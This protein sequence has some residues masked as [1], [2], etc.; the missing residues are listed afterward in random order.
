VTEGLSGSIAASGQDTFTV[1]LN[2]TSAGTFQGDVSFG[3]N[4]ADENPFN[5]RI[6]GEV[7]TAPEPEIETRGNS[8]V[9]AD[10]DTTPSLADH[11]DFGTTTVGAPV[12]HTFTVRNEGTAALT[13]SG[14]TV[15][16]GF[17]VTEG[18]SG[19]IAASGQDTFTVRLNATSAGT[20]QGDVSFGNNDSDENPF[21][22]RIRGEVTGGGGTAV[23]SISGATVTIAVSP[24]PGTSAW[25]L[26]ELIP[27]GLTPS[28]IT[29]PN[30]S[31][32]SSTRKITWYGTGDS[33][34]T[35]GYTVSGDEGTYTVAGTV[36]FDG[37]ANQTVTG[38]ATITI[39]A[40]HPADLNRNWSM[41]MSEAIGYAAGW[42]QGANPMAYA[43]RAL[44]LW[45]NGEA[46]HREAGAEPMCWVADNPSAMGAAAYVQTTA[47][48]AV[49]T[50]TDGPVSGTVSIAVSPP[51]G[52]SAWG[53]EE[54]IPVGL[55]PA[56]ITG[57]NASWNDSTRKIT[58]YATGDAAATLG[59]TVTGPANSYALDGNVNFDGG[60]N[61]PITGETD[62]YLGAFGGAFDGGSNRK[63]VDWF[64]WY[65]DEYWP[66]IWDYE[67]GCW[68]WVVDNGPE[69]VWF[70][71]DD[72]A[73]WMWTRCDWYHWVWY[74]GD[75]GLTWRSN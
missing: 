32:N 30:G 67:F 57:P 10:G 61:D 58:W 63:Y 18:L 50:I 46:Y 24:Q 69:N 16:S 54:E 62:L 43:I 23:R 40:T 37:G 72:G 39:A 60:L 15:P 14:L 56:N 44:Y 42:Q 7:S 6:R 4:D 74:P 13:T 51:A 25:G 22:F 36:N 1:R 49:R 52:T 8:V 41:V 66:W 3:N 59:Y 29:G 5:F 55:T 19:S 31:W 47:E 2:A 73:T 21:N 33:P 34:A 65:N 45:Q 27:S 20:F 70:W 17:T 11:T 28:G 12:S 71:C 35:L 53:C 75:P 68:L 26:E 38:P 48:G 64:G 9:I